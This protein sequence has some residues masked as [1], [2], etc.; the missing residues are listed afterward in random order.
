MIVVLLGLF[1][2]TDAAFFW[3]AE[4]AEY[5]EA[6]TEILFHFCVFPRNSAGK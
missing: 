2:A 4:Y 6:G 1:D 3:P 5:A